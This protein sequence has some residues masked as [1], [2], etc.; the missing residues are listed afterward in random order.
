ME[1]SDSLQKRFYIVRSA[2]SSD[3]EAILKIYN[4]GIEDRIAT[5]ETETKNMDY[6]RSWI[7]DHQDRY[8]VLVAEN[9]GRLVGWASLNRY[10]QRR[11]YDGVADLSIYI[12]REYRGKGVGG[13]LLSALE[14]AAKE[15]QFYKIILFTF[16][17]NIAGQKLYRRH[18]YRE[19]GIFEKQGVLDGNMV[20]VMIMEK[21]LKKQT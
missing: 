16:P 3:L 14:Q 2:L 5:L 1:P 8:Q 6:M 12:L 11:A 17:N 18:G 13:H 4:Q 9:E 10:S 19:V 20:D 15:N 21:M 7:E